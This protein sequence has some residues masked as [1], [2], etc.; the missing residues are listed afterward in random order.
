[1]YLTCMKHWALLGRSH[2]VIRCTRNSN[3]SC[4][5]AGRHTIKPLLLCLETLTFCSMIILNCTVWVWPWL[6]TLKQPVSILTRVIDMGI[7]CTSVR[8]SDRA[9][10]SVIVSK[11]LRYIIKPS[12]RAIILVFVPRA[13]V[14]PHNRRAA[15]RQ[16]YLCE[17][18]LH[19]LTQ[20]NVDARS[21]PIANLRAELEV[22]TV[23]HVYC[24]QSLNVLRLVDY[25]FLR[26]DGV[27]LF[28]YLHNIS[29]RTIA[30]HR[31][32]PL[33]CRCYVSTEWTI[34]SNL[35]SY[36]QEHLASNINNKS[37]VVNV[38]L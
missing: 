2:F 18:S 10:R 8:L 32:F 37:L 33:Y 14:V 11:R 20:T 23:T 12:G 28:K 34:V 27:D 9:S 7:T 38:G 19:R 16:K 26:Y 24:W 1:M 25:L 15:Q 29:P 3:L 22:L 21:M 13:S 30:L 17:N 4:G 35:A 6:L 36:I 31:T 5:T